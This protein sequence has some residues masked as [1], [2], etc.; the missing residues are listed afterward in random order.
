MRKKVIFFLIISICL[1]FFVHT[2]QAVECPSKGDVFPEVTLSV[3]EKANE[4]NYLGINGKG[5][6][7][8]SQIKAEMVMLEVFSMYCPYCQKEAPLVNELFQMISERPD[9]KNKIKIIGIGAGNTAF[10]V[11]VFRDKYNIPFPLFPD[12]SFS[13]HKAVGEVR[14]PYFFVFKINAD[15]SNNIIYSKAGSIQDPKQF[16]DLI[17]KESGL[18]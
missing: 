8:I 5:T 3:P 2:V 15:G 16:L 4:K 12:E 10:E 6:F 9:L 14:T 1:T 13:I 11:E 7:K 18:K 17:I